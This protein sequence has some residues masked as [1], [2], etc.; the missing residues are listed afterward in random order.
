[1]TSMYEFVFFKLNLPKT[2]KILKSVISCNLDLKLYH[3]GKKKISSDCKHLP[4]VQI[5]S[6]DPNFECQ[7][8]ID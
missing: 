2:G 8:N 6:L 3:F 5:V 1:M 4:F 7:S